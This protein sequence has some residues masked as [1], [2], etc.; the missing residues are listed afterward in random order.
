MAEVE[1]KID[2]K[3]TQDMRMAFVCSLWYPKP[4]AVGGQPSG[5]SFAVWTLYVAI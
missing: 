3:S 5:E 1:R 2:V 4:L